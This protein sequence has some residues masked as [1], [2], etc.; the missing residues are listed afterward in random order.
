MKIFTAAGLDPEKDE[1]AKQVISSLYEERSKREPSKKRAFGVAANAELLTILGTRSVS[2]NKVGRL[3]DL[4]F[5]HCEVERNDSLEHFL[6]R[7]ISRILE[8]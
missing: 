4:F 6:K 7:N 2:K 1:E 5:E 3:V 8:D